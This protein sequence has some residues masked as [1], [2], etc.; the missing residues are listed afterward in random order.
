[1]FDQMS[2]VSPSQAYEVSQSSVA[3]TSSWEW[4]DSTSHMLTAFQPFIIITLETMIGMYFYTKKSR[5][6][7]THTKAMIENLK[8]CVD[9]AYIEA[10]LRNLGVV[11]QD[12]GVSEL[13]EWASMYAFIELEKFGEKVEKPNATRPRPLLIIGDSGSG[14]TFIVD[15]LLKHVLKVPRLSNTV[16]K[17]ASPLDTMIQLCEQTNGKYGITFYDEF[18]K[19]ARTPDGFEA[20]IALLKPME[21]ADLPQN[22]NPF[23]ALLGNETEVLHT[24]FM[25]MIFAGSFSD[26]LSG[27]AL[28]HIVTERLT[29]EG[30]K[31]E[32]GKSWTHY[33]K[34][35]DIK[36]YKITGDLINRLQ[37]I[38]FD[39]LTEDNMFDIIDKSS[40]NQVNETKRYIKNS[41]NV[42]LV[43]NQLVKKKMAKHVLS[44]GKEGRGAGKIIDILRSVIYRKFKNR[45]KKKAMTYEVTE[46]DIEET[47]VR[48][49]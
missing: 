24:R 35:D 32:D 2:D 39:P 48:I 49:V 20:Q 16:K 47:L 1:M 33:Y 46:A 11:G 5:A 8:K 18:D 31:I 37:I 14:K 44:G 9:P 26:T 17:G 23:A 27:E 4:T 12:R 41:C 30:K 22:P 3:P 21:G 45:D 6:V 34:E 13:A 19:F 25:G 15:L 7:S 42:D 10:E 40:V 38:M 36:K 43:L 28:K 29:L